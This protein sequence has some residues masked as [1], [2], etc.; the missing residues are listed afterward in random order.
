MKVPV[1]LRAG[2]QCK[3]SCSMEN[4][5]KD[6]KAVTSAVICQVAPGTSP[7]HAVLAARLS[8]CSF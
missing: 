4:S 5:L 1:L 7:T 2:K 3:M 8:I 6:R